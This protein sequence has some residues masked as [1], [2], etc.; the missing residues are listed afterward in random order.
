M[1]EKTIKVVLRMSS[2][3]LVLAFFLACCSMKILE[4]AFMELSLRHFEP[5]VKGA[6]KHVNFDKLRI[7]KVNKTSHLFIGELEV[8]EESFGN[9]YQ[10]E[11]LIYKMAGN[12]YKLLPYHMGPDGWCEFI[13]KQVLMYEDFRKASDFPP[14][15]DVSNFILKCSKKM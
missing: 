11:S 3:R 12:D 7:R 15:N 8:F 10:I 14:V 1:N 13:K 2:P 6:T 9:Q 4:T 5:L